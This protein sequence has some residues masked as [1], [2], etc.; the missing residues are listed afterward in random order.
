[1]EKVKKLFVA[2]N[3]IEIMRWI[4]MERC[5]EEVHIEFDKKFPKI[6][7]LKSELKIPTKACE[8]V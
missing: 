6:I 7:H 4:K 2:L 5:F 1:V 3:I 8:M